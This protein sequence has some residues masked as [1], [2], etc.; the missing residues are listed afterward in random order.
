L[1]YKPTSF[2]PQSLVARTPGDFVATAC[3][4]LAQIAA[5]R[6][7]AQRPGA[8][9]AATYGAARARLARAAAPGAPGVFDFA[10]WTREWERA[11]VL[12]VRE[13]AA[14]GWAGGAAATH[15][16]AARDAGGDRA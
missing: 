1:L 15:L 3:A 16:V 8:A 11:L 10:G 13:S 9:P 2:V 6:A 5:A 12:A 14:R 7:A 4:L